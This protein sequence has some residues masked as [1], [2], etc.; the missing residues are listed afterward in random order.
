M[1]GVDVQHDVNAQHGV[2]EKPTRPYDNENPS[3]I[4][5]MATISSALMT[6]SIHYHGEN[7]K[8]PF[9]SENPYDSENT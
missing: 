4:P 6:A 5:L 9:D 7:L 3:K 8:R 2:D 1:W